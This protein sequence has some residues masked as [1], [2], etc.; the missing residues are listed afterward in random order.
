MNFPGSSVAL[1]NIAIVAFLVSPIHSQKPISDTRSRTA[2]ISGRVFQG[3]NPGVNVVLRLRELPPDGGSGE[4]QPAYSLLSLKLR[5]DGEGRY[6]FSNLPAGKYL[7]SASSPAYISRKSVADSEAQGLIELE[8][9]ENIEDRNYDLIRGGVITGRITDPDDRPMI[10]QNIQLLPLNEKGEVTQQGFSF[11]YGSMMETD[12]RGVYRIY[13]VAPGRYKLRVAGGKLHGSGRAKLPDM[14]YPDAITI[15]K[16]ETI[17]VQ[18]GAEVTGI[19]IRIGSAQKAYELSGTVISA[20]TGKPLPGA[21]LW[22]REVRDQAEDWQDSSNYNTKSDAQ[23]NFKVSSLSNG[24]YEINIG[25]DWLQN[26]EFFSERVPVEIRE[27]DISGIVVKALRGATIAGKV[28]IDDNAEPAIKARLSKIILQVVSM[29]AKEGVQEGASAGQAWAKVSEDGSFH[30]AGFPPG[31]VLFLLGWD[32][33]DS[34]QIDRIERN[35]ST[36]QKLEIGA[37]EQISDVRIF[38]VNAKGMIRGQV[39][40]VGGK[41]PAG[42][43]LYASA[44]KSGRTEDQKQGR[45]YPSMQAEAF[46]D[47]KGRFVLSGL[48]SGEYTVTITPRMN[49]HGEAREAG[50]AASVTQRV[51]VPGSGETAV[52]ISFD[53]SRK[54]EG[55]Q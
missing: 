18:E 50:L 23:G 54:A 9:G 53:P 52:T 44:E 19:D 2:S 13:G 36:I 14:Y 26:K 15:Q 5:T 29:P 35:G 33:T 39:N 37:G 21:L 30:A 46:I 45:L 6:R 25:N 43:I 17:E 28:F 24:K 48:V 7:L 51:S 1:L 40:V 47:A 38:I 12:D 8:D 31:N 34:L 32:F 27:G 41:L 42:W 22:V 49:I 16:A 4:K 11:E 3:G 55:R 20:E 10:A